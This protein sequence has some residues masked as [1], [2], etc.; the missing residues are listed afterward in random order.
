M[1]LLYA[2][3]GAP[4]FAF[5][6]VDWNGTVVPCFGRPAHR[7]ALETLAL[8]R[9][10]GVPLFVVSR[11]PQ[12]IVAADVARAG[13]EA[14][15]VIGCIDKAPPLSDLR[16]QHGLGLLIGDTAADQRAA[17]EAGVG[18]LQ[19]RLEGEA[20]LPG[21]TDSFTAWEDARRWLLAGDPPQL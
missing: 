17:A 3:M 4:R 8:L 19:A 14:D 11:A 13:L 2:A 18:F 12:R 1:A 6:A 10:R 9:A 5:L 21:A 20:E 15:G 16:L 7:G